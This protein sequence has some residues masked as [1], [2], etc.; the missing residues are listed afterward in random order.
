MGYLQRLATSTSVNNCYLSCVLQGSYHKLLNNWIRQVSLLSRQ[1]Y[2]SFGVKKKRPGLLASC[3]TRGC[4]VF[5]HFISITD[6]PTFGVGKIGI[7]FDN[8]GITRAPKGRATRG[9]S[10]QSPPE[11]FE[12]LILRDAIS[13]FLRAQF[14]SKM[15]AYSILIFILIY[16][17]SHTNI[18]FYF[19]FPW[20]FLS[21]LVYQFS[22]LILW[23]AFLCEYHKNSFG[24]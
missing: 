21:F 11:K 24:I 4:T 22:L 7:F 12:I 9:L 23:Y 17:A 18:R 20:N 15:F 3:V 5:E 16:A 2:P 8:W 13:S 10:N 14:L 19:T 1:G 6:C